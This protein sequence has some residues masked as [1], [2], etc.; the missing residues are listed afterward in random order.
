M[1]SFLVIS[2]ISICSNSKQLFFS[3]VYFELEAFFYSFS[4]GLSPC[5]PGLLKLIKFFTMTS[6]KVQWFLDF[7]L[8]E[9]G[10]IYYNKLVKAHEKIVYSSKAIPDTPNL[11]CFKNL[12]N[13]L[14]CRIFPRCNP[15]FS[16]GKCVLLAISASVMETLG[17]LRIFFLQK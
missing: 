12:M 1:S 7:D 3:K 17:I 11:C 16:L 4:M 15:V 8:L 10:S 13:L 14:S 6:G 9:W 5:S 2:P